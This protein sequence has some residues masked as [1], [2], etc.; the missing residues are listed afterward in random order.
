VVAI[1]GGT[2]SLSLNVATGL[3][4][5][6]GDGNNQIIDTTKS[7]LVPMIFNST[8]GITDGNAFDPSTNILLLSQEVGADQTVAFNFATLNTASPPATARNITVPG[9]GEAEPIGEGPGG[10]AAINFMTHQAVV[11]DEFGQNF[12]LIQLPVA[13]VAGPLNNNTPVDPASVYTIAA[14]VIPKGVVGGVPTQLAIL[15]DPNSL[16]IDSA[17]NVAYMLADTIAGFHNWTPGSSLPLFLVRVDLSKPVPG[18]C[19]IAA[20]GPK[21]FPVSVAIPLPIL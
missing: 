16:T 4:F 9:L 20:C 21:W 2:D 11:A 3:I 14:A 10:Q 17:N 18:A 12:K 15:G 8:F 7:P 6:S 5:I 13:P 19:P 1:P